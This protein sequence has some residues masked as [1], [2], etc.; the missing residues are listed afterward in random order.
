MTNVSPGVVLGMLFLTL[1]DTNVDFSSQELYW[2]TYI[3]KEAFP[4]TKR[5]EL[6]GKIEFLAAAFNPEHETYIVY[7]AS[8][9][10]TPLVTSPDSTS[11]DVH[12]SW[13]P[14]ISGLI[15]KK[16]STKIPDEYADFANVFSL[17]LASKLPKHIGINNYAIK[18]ING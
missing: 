17:D 18:L 1:G 14:Q 9:S 2:K 12:P 8:L 11:L 4:A 15:A 13:R 7:V 6:V 5:I 10:S 3:T 16:A